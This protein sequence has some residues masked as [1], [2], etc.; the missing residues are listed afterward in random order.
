[1]PASRPPHSGGFYSFPMHSCRH[2][3][4]SHQP[5]PTPPTPPV[6]QNNPQCGWA[7]ET[8][9]MKTYISPSHN[10][11]LFTKVK[12]SI[13]FCLRTQ[14][15]VLSLY[16]CFNPIEC[17]FLVAKVISSTKLTFCFLV[18]TPQGLLARGDLR[19][20]FVEK[21][22]H[23][24]PVIQL[25]EYGAQTTAVNGYAHQHKSS[26]PHY[27]TRGNVAAAGMPEEKMSRS[28][29]NEHASHSRSGTHAS[30]SHST[31]STNATPSPNS[32]T[33]SYTHTSIPSTL[34]SSS[35]GYAS[36]D[37]NNMGHHSLM[38]SSAPDLHHYSPRSKGSLGTLS[39]GE[40]A[41]FT[42]SWSGYGSSGV[43]PHMQKS[44]S[45]ESAE[46]VMRV[47]QHSLMRPTSLV[48]PNAGGGTS[49]AQQAQQFF[50]CPNCKR[51]FSCAVGDTFEPWF[52]HIKACNV[53][54]A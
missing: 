42:S 16:F 50:S 4:Q 11:K 45:Q 48:L 28:Y 32:G 33:S 23:S 13:K 22:E 17:K 38:R 1:M 9:C 52:D 15:K 41:E 19:G 47:Q 51:T 54:N 34:S 36:V 46:D 40:E 43:R 53:Q 12:S 24:I 7:L 27:S 3:I 25:E 8:Q 49:Q 31:F 37:S 18:L 2:N 39:S 26:E 30:H 5:D 10:I 21:D 20:G 14:L 29:S 35:L 44:L 6:S